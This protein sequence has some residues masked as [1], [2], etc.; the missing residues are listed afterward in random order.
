MLYGPC[1]RFAQG[2]MDHPTRY[3]WIGLQIVGNDVRKVCRVIVLVQLRDFGGDDAVRQ[4]VE[5]PVA[6]LQHH[7]VEGSGVLQV[8]E[9]VHDP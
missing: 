6:R 2:R 5:L 4:V 9:I 1:A 7:S 3:H 8:F